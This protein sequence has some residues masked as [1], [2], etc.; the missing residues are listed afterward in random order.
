MGSREEASAEPRSTVWAVGLRT[1]Q[2]G[3]VMGVGGR[4]TLE[5]GTGVRV[6]P[7]DES[8]SPRHSRGGSTERITGSTL[9]EVA[10]P[11]AFQVAWTVFVL[12]VS[13]FSLF[14]LFRKRGH[15]SRQFILSLPMSRFCMKV[16]AKVINMI[17]PGDKLA[18]SSQIPSM[19]P[20]TPWQGLPLFSTQ[21]APPG[22]LTPHNLPDPGLSPWQPSRMEASRRRP[23]KSQIRATSAGSRG[24]ALYP[25]WPLGMSP[26]TLWPTCSVPTLLLLARPRLVSARVSVR[27][28]LP[29]PGLLAH[30][31]TNNNSHWINI[32]GIVFL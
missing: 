8:S 27:L 15:P 9:S 19:T 24:R 30:E 7:A 1:L 5:P 26:R 16:I 31:M 10:W 32:A 20:A 6:K 3:R 25:L 22:T 4:G 2:A 13:L 21:A 12:F 28:V 14:F 17:D 18:P 11:L 23:D 29:R